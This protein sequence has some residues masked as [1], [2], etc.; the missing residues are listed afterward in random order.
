[1]NFRNPPTGVKNNEFPPASILTT[2]IIT[3]V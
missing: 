3:T 1:L 2:R